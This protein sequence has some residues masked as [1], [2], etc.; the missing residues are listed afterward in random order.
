M[1]S[2]LRISRKRVRFCWFLFPKH[3]DRNWRIKLVISCLINV[4]LNSQHLEM[5][6]KFYHT[7]CSSVYWAFV[8]WQTGSIL[9][10]TWLHADLALGVQLALLETLGVGWL[11]AGWCAAVD[12]RRTAGAVTARRVGRG[13]VSSEARG[14]AG[15][16]SVHLC[17]GTCASGRE[18][19]RLSILSRTGWFLPVRP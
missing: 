3:L 11:W 19:T 2:F 14:C 18:V 7:F 13:L 12:G 15:C 10:V 9:L 5:S 8:I 4:L 1:S 17:S 16:E 6:E